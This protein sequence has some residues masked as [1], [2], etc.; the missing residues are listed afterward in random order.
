MGV[1]S[2]AGRE[3]NAFFAS[4]IKLL[5]TTKA[6]SR[7]TLCSAKWSSRAKREMIARDNGVFYSSDCV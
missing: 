1:S 5:H 2:H 7:F 4:N 3:A 6:V